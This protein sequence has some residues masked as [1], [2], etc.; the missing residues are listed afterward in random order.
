LH[1]QLDAPSA[2]AFTERLK[3]P[4]GPLAH[5][6]DTITSGGRSAKRFEK[7]NPGAADAPGHLTSPLTT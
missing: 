3:K 7:S 2:I 5:S 4:P 1:A 6:A